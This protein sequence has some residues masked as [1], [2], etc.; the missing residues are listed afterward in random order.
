MSEPALVVLVRFK[1]SLPRDEMTRVMEKRAPGFRA[2]KGLQQKYYMED[3]VSGEVA[4]LY[5]WESAE[6]ATAY[7]ESDLRASIAEAYQAVSE[8]RVDVF[9]VMKTLRE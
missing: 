2:L 9:R 1:S 6:D 3:P 7:R 8:P 5:L 4:G